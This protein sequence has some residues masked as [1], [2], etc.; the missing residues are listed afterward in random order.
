MCKWSTAAALFDVDRIG[1][2]GAGCVLAE[3]GYSSG[4]CILFGLFEKLFSL[5]LLV[6]YS[7]ME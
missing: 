6:C 5:V 4:E 7:Y 1:P 3:S 2:R